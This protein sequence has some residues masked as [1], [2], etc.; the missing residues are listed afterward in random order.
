MDSD[1]ARKHPRLTLEDRLLIEELLK[2]G[3]TFAEIANRLSR[4][5]ATI[6]KE[7]AKNGGSQNYKAHIANQSYLKRISRC[8]RKNEIDYGDMLGIYDGIQQGKSIADIAKQLGVSRTVVANEVKA[9]GGRDFYNPY[10]NCK[11]SNEPIKEKYEEDLFNL[12]KPPSPVPAE[13][14]LPL[15]FSTVEEPTSPENPLPITS[16]HIP[17]DLC[18]RLVALEMQVEILCE[19]MKEILRSKN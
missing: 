17:H 3:R 12:P 1:N 6:G 4:P 15:N 11:N 7:I 2:R 5:P 13:K 19:S 9:R 10:E 18:K 8:G 16:I 14:P